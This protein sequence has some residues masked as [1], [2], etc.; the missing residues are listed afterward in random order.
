MGK[1]FKLKQPHE[2]I[3]CDFAKHVIS[4]VLIKQ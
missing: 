4:F 1:K 3:G 2:I